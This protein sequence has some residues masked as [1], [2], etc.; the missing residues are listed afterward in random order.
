MREFQRAGHTVPGNVAVTGFDDIYASRI[1]TPAVTT[2][3][4]PLRDLGRTAAE[5]L[6]AR[7]D[8]RRLPARAAILPTHLV[9]RG[10]CGCP[11]R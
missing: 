1:V 6:R 11:A 7:I 5:R 10:S 2:V 8:D 3:S 9:I 4:Q